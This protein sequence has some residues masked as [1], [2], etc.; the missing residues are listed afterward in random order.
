MALSAKR[1]RVRRGARAAAPGARPEIAAPPDQLTPDGA[2]KGTVGF[3]LS[4]PRY[5]HFREGQTIFDGFAAE[6]GLAA[7]MPMI[8][9][10]TLRLVTS[11]V[12]PIELRDHADN[13]VRH[14]IGT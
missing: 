9:T 3:P 13:R 7:T 12:F 14:A 4:A 1:G 8:S 6:N 5:I 10:G 11:E 2:D